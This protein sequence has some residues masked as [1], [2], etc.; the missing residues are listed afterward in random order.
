[1]GDEVIPSHPTHRDSYPSF[2]EG[3]CEDYHFSVLPHGVPFPLAAIS[4][5]SPRRNTVVNFKA[6]YTFRGIYQVSKSAHLKDS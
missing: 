6:L 5:G 1:M 2:Y 3:N 4:N